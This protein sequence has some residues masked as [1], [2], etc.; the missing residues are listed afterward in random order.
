M[1]MIVT[2]A[3]GFV[4]SS[5]CEALLDTGHEVVG[6]DSFLGN[7]DTGLKAQNLA[8]ILGHPC[9]TFV[10]TDLRTADLRPVVEGADVIFHQ[11]GQPGVRTSWAD[12]F[13][14]HLENN[15]RA[16]QRLLEA[17][18]GC[19]SL[20][21][22]VYASSSSVYGNIP[23]WP[24]DENDPTA[25]NSPYGVTKLAAEH[26]CGV[27]ARNHDLP[28]VSLRYFTVYGPKQRPD[29]A[30]FRLISTA[31]AGSTF[32]LYGDGSHVRDFTYVGDVVGANLL[33]ARADLEP[34]TV[35][36][37][38]GGESVSMARLIELVGEVSG[39]PVKV[40]RTG[41]K[42]GDVARTGGAIDRAWE[43][44]GWEPKVSLRHGIEQQVAWHRDLV[45][46][47]DDGTSLVAS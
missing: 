33:A 30:I 38:A 1:R 12:G 10:K 43:L 37:V 35:M 11:A 8:P 15:V 25:P 45:L 42:A 34:G 31:L 26:L 36:N 3:A 13:T 18:K 24:L 40:R 23:R 27:Y 14:S 28:V 22:L 5:I 19:R 20:R 4:G 29:M 47:L 2:G 41:E 7:Y 44:L 21:R 16:T 32:E 46:A 39:S 17:A 6:I 9:M